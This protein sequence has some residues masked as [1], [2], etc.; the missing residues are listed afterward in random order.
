MSYLL[1]ETCL[2]SATATEE[3]DPRSHWDET[4]LIMAA[5]SQKSLPTCDFL[6]SEGADMQVP[7]VDPVKWRKWLSECE[8]TCG[9]KAW[10]SKILPDSLHIITLHCA[11]RKPQ[12]LFFAYTVESIDL[13]SFV[14]IWPF[15][16]SWT[17]RV[18]AWSN[19][20][21]CLI[22]RGKDELQQRCSESWQRVA[23][24][25]ETWPLSLTWF[26][27]IFHLGY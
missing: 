2:N 6:V 13:E 25:F 23:D 15:F 11:P 22:P 17:S 16:V 1:V 3:I 14:W 27:N 5:R 18:R 8:K 20:T 26:S 21:N 24:K 7:G 9:M 4:P 12:R 10:S 19:S